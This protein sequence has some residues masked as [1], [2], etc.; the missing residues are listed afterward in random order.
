MVINNPNVMSSFLKPFCNYLP[1]HWIV[2][3]TVDGITYIYHF[4]I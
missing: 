1:E 3:A 4:M 2:Y